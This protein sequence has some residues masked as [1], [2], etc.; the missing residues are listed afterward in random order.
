MKFINRHSA[1]IAAALFATAPIFISNQAKAADTGVTQQ[2][3]TK[4]TNQTNPSGQ[5]KD[6]T[7]KPAT[8]V[9]AKT[10]NQKSEPGSSIDNPIQITLKYNDNLKE[11]NYKIKQTNNLTM[12]DLSDYVKKN[13]DVYLQGKLSKINLSTSGGTVDVIGIKDKDGNRVDWMKKGYG[14]PLLIKGDSINIWSGINGLDKNTWYTWISTDYPHIPRDKDGEIPDA[15]KGKYNIKNLNNGTYQITVKT[16]NE[17]NFGKVIFK[18]T[19]DGVSR[20]DSTQYLLPQLTFLVT[21]KDGKVIPVTGYRKPTPRKLKGEITSDSTSAD[22][23]V[24]KANRA[25]DATT[26]TPDET[27]KPVTIPTIDS[28][29]SQT[30]TNPTSNTTNSDSKPIIDKDKKESTPSVSKKVPTSTPKKQSTTL[31]LMLDHNAYV[32][33]KN[34]KV[35]KNKKGHYYVLPRYKNITALS[36]GK[37][38]TIKGKK[39][40]QIGKN[41]FIK[42]VN[43]TKRPTAKKFVS[44]ATVK[45]VKGNK[46][47][48]YSENGKYTK[49][50]LSSKKGI[51]LTKVKKIKGKKFYQI[52]GTNYWIPAA[53]VTLKK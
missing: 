40:Y 3:P 5:I 6:N 31:P 12:E 50:Y 41:K 7:Q 49:K 4:A 52:K 11:R 30:E 28:N 17:G 21:D 47:R 2:Q 23:D 19:K 48:L 10:L 26:S 24:D 44:S 42:V 36:N 22:S 29:V 27:P 14:N 15:I 32:Y 8:T 9:P 35:T 39:F 45:T 33:D 20:E 53:K 38:V 25:S 37:I 46:V 13:I 16:D 34:G 18:E 1:A 51:K 43:T